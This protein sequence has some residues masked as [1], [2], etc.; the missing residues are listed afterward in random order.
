MGWKGSVK[1]KEV[2]SSDHYYLTA[3][4]REIGFLAE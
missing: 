3:R 2:E 4:S 1:D